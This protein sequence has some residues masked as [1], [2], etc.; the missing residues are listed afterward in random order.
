MRNNI[1][2]LII[3]LI[4]AVFAVDLIVRVS[5]GY[6]GFGFQWLGII[7]VVLYSLWIRYFIRENILNKIKFFKYGGISRP[8]MAAAMF[9]LFVAMIFDL[10]GKERV[11]NGFAIIV[12]YFL[13]ETVIIEMINIRK[14]ENTEEKEDA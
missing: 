14:K 7:V 11:A 10:S 9:F 2:F 3:N 1:A 6:V 13:I 5:N 4:G 8:Y 12:Y